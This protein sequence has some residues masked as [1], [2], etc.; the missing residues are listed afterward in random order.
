MWL[1]EATHLP[2]GSSYLCDNVAQ[3]RRTDGERL[4]DA[5]H[6]NIKTTQIYARITSKKIEHDMEQLAG[7]LD[8][9]NQAMGL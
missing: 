8:K 5:R 3:Q 6:T 1:T 7:K 2:S 4:Q 9:F